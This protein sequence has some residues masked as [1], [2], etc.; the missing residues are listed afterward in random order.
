MSTLGPWLGDA[1]NR[2]DRE[3]AALAAELQA[4]AATLPDDDDGAQVVRLARHTLLAHLGDADALQRFLAAL[5]RSPKLQA[6]ADQAD[7]ALATLAGRPVAP[8]PEAAAWSTLADVVQAEILRGRLAQARERALA[9][10]A[11]AAAHPD[12]AARRAYAITAHNLALALRVGPRSPAHDALMIEM[13]E[14]ERRAWSRAGTWLQVERA[15]YHLALCHA[16]A[17][18]GPRAVACAAACRE[19]CEAHGADAAERFF[20]HE[21]S[22][23]AARAA[24]DANA[25]AQHRARMVSLL[26]DV[27][28]A[29][30]KAF[31][32]ETLAATPH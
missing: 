14:L 3:S 22:V 10:E 6:P 17:G 32:E 20:A 25:A 24:G 11:A 16:V 26:A 9:P 31:C 1:W 21:C 30:M 27:Q 4:L 15:D 18:Q 8:L 13:A 12:E 7:W 5:P 23:H 28:D 29:Q 19:A 2:H